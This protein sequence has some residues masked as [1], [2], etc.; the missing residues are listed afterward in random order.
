M[1]KGIFFGDTFF[2]LLVYRLDLNHLLMSILASKRFSKSSGYP[3][4][5]LLIFIMVSNITGLSIISFPLLH[6]YCYLWN[7]R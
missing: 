2:V 3:S 5:L 4:R 1:K 7:I 6:Y